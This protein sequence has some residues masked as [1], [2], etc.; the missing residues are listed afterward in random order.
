MPK[1]LEPYRKF[2]TRKGKTVAAGSTAIAGD[3]PRWMVPL[4]KRLLRYGYEVT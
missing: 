3:T 1:F 4:I 2:L